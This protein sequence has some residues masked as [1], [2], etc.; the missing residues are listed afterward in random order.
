MIPETNINI[1][2]ERLIDSVIRWGLC[3]SNGNVI[4]G[5]KKKIDAFYKSENPSTKSFGEYLN[6]MFAP[7]GFHAVTVPIDDHTPYKPYSIIFNNAGLHFFYRDEN[8]IIH[9]ENIEWREFA[10]RTAKMILNNEYFTDKQA[11]FRTEKNKDRE[12]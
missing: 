2:R 12:R 10:K 3:D 6:K 7:C 8:Q 5:S 11:V 9:P 4:E 1:K